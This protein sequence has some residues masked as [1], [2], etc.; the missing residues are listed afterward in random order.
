MV[1]N[2]CYR[3]AFE[4]PGYFTVTAKLL[5]LANDFD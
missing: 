4:A 3:T 2:T 1:T 5:K